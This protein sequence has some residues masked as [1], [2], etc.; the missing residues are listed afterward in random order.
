MDDR[1]LLV[2]PAVAVLVAE[3]RKRPAWQSDKPLLVPPDLYDAA[4]SE[5]EAI[6]KKRG[7]RLGM[8][9]AVKAENFLLQGTAIVSGHG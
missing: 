9:K 2:A 6:M 3:L 4:R 7:F 8:S 1:P 5:M